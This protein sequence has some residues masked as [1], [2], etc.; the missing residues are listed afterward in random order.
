MKSEFSKSEKEVM[1]K[2]LDEF[3]KDLQAWFGLSYAQFLTIPRLVMESMSDEWQEKMALLLNK[4]DD[5]FDW[6]PAEGKYWVRLR[7]DKGRFSVPSLCDYHRGNI[8]HSRIKNEE[9]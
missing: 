8:E 2:E 5:T 7:N 1:M 4:M 9:S 6:L 3:N